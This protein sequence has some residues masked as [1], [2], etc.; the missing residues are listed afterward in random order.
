MGAVNDELLKRLGISESQLRLDLDQSRVESKNPGI[1]GAHLEHAVRQFVSDWTPG[2]VRVGCGE[3]FDA[4]SNKSQQCDGIVLNDEQPFWRGLDS[5]APYLIEGVESIFEIKTN[6]GTKELRDVLS[7][8]EVAS[9]LR[10]TH[11]HGDQLLAR[12]SRYTEIRPFWAIAI[13]S[14]LSTKG[15][16]S[17]LKADQP[18]ALDALFVLDR[19]AFINFRSDVW[20]ALWTDEAGKSQLGWHLVEETNVLSALVGWVNATLPRIRSNQPIIL[21]YMK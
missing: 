7:K 5:S 17:R 12:P 6:L 16:L 2:N 18:D 15:I 3:V 19:G 9:R 11:S 8:A 10:P 14:S 20:Q 21:N 13:E 1:K 4:M